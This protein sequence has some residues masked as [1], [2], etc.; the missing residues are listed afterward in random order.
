MLAI[1]ITT[2]M[3]GQ[4]LVMQF[5]LGNSQAFRGCWKIA[6]SYMKKTFC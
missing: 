5:C 1:K 2:E 6:W 3:V 4:Y